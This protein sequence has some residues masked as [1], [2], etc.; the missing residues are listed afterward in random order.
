MDLCVFLRPKLALLCGVC[1]CDVA[2]VGR[3]NERTNE[4][5]QFNEP[6]AQRDGRVIEEPPLTRET[7]TRKRVEL[8]RTCDLNHARRR[9]NRHLLGLRIVGVDDVMPAVRRLALVIHHRTQL[10]RDSN[11]AIVYEC[12]NVN[13]FLQ[14]AVSNALFFTWYVVPSVVFTS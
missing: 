2:S 8:A 14:N 12:N 5:H 7:E 4:R 9:A 11:Q 1:V 3:T 13:F 6:F 10:R